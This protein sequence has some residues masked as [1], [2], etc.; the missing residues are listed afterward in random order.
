MA[1]GKCIHCE[2]GV[3]LH[4]DG[5]HRS[6]G[7]EVPCQR[8]MTAEEDALMWKSLLDSVTF[9]DDL[10]KRQEPLGSE[11]AAVLFDNL[12]DLYLR[13]EPETAALT[14]SVTPH[15]EGGA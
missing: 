8:E 12:D 14:H 15:N 3:A 13:D 6:L 11:F 10:V 4:D 1:D 7:W 9:V 2:A 5:K